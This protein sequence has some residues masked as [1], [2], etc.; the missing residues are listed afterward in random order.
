M[1]LHGFMLGGGR[2]V[3]GWPEGRGVKLQ[4]NPRWPVCCGAH[5]WDIFNGS[6]CFVCICVASGLCGH[7]GQ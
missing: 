5:G 7:D 3:S 6:S 1:G 2:N 4:G